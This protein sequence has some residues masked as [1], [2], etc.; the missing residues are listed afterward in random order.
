MKPY[1]KTDRGVLYCG[2][3]LEI[4]P[5]L[6]EKADLCLTDP[7]YGM[8]Y[9]SSWRKH[10]F[11][12]IID[13]DNLEW[14]KSFIPILYDSMKKNTHSYLFCNDYNM[15]E[16]IKTGMDCGFTR[17]RSLVWVKN[18]HTFGDLLGDY[19]NKTEFVVFFHK[20]RKLLNNK[21]DTNVLNYSK[22]PSEFH[23]TQK[24]ILLMEYLLK[25]SSEENDLIIDPFGGSGTTALACENL[26]RRWIMI[27]KE[28][29]YCEIIKK[30]VVTF[31]KQKRVITPENDWF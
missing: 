18:N 3:S 25:K 11:N 20:G 9:V 15:S 7:P 5:Q 6:K 13:D 1:F 17:K 21:R 26:N 19:G 30:R 4:L 23:P 27:E 22:T 10:K 14:I 8:S 28:P 2:D 24:P 16:L 31:L 29:K 12:M